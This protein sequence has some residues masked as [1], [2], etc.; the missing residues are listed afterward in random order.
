VIVRIVLV[1]AL[2]VALVTGS[3]IANNAPPD[4]EAQLFELDADDE[5]ITVSVAV[6]AH[7][8]SPAPSIDQGTETDHTSPDLGGVF[9]PPRGALVRVA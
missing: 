9:R 1:I 3:A 6:D 2:A 5:M 4:V 7:I 8:A